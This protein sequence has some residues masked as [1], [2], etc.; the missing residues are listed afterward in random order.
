MMIRLELLVLLITYCSCQFCPIGYSDLRQGTP[1]TATTYCQV[2]GGG[3]YTCVRGYCCRSNIA[4]DDANYCRARRSSIQRT[5][6]GGVVDCFAQ[7]CR[8]GYQC[9]YSEA[10]AI[11]ICCSTSP[12]VPQFDDAPGTVRLVPGTARAVQC[13]EPNH[14]LWV[15][16]P[17]CVDSNEWGYKVCCSTFNCN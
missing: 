9:E 7:Q 16:T 4:Q 14:C 13:F 1:C 8:Q 11:Y 3:S 6:D 17:N 12:G 2:V 5:S 10:L 15:D